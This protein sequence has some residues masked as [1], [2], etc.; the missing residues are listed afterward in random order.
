MPSSPRHQHLDPKLGAKTKL[1]IY[2]G[3]QIRLYVGGDIRDVQYVTTTVGVIYYNDWNYSFELGVRTLLY[4][5]QSFKDLDRNFDVD[6]WE[7][8]PNLIFIGGVYYF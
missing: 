8:A 3:E 1:W 2:P 7:N 5:D 4:E 6:P